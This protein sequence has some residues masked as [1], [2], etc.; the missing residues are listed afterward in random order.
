MLKINYCR[1]GELVSDF[2][3][4]DFVDRKI[5]EYLN[6]PRNDLEVRV[7]NEIAQ[8]AFVLRVFEGLIPEHDI[9]FYFEGVKLNFDKYFGIECPKNV[10]DF[11]INNE[12][13][14]KILK[15]GY[16]RMIAD[17]K[18]ESP[19]KPENMWEA[20]KYAID[21]MTGT[22]LKNWCSK[23]GL[24][25]RSEIPDWVLRGHENE[26]EEIDIWYEE[27]FAACFY[28]KNDLLVR[29]EVDN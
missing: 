27:K 28:D 22:D 9:E 8:N 14:Q 3:V 15:L 7:A 2:S 16:D 23:N 17:R 24:V 4:Y 13:I 19:V 12:M 11:E 10:S 26:F 18:K 5:E 21:N 29:K 1:N 20:V 6:S 25:Y